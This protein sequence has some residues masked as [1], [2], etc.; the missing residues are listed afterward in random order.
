MILRQ[1]VEKK[2]FYIKYYKS[3][4]GILA[5]TDKQL[6]VLAEFST[7]RNSMPDDYT[8]DQK[9]TYTFTSASRNIIADRLEISIY[10]LNNVI[11]SL[12]D[13]GF[14]FPKGDTYFLNPSIYT[15]IDKEEKEIVFKFNIK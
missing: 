11:R 12:K 8:E 14:L 3:L 13:K 10:N 1:T 9:D 15:P 4:N 6:Q 5:L 2:N 7:V